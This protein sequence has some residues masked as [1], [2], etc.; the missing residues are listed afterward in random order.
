MKPVF[1]YIY[2]PVPSWRLGSSL[3][4]DLLSQEEKICNFDCVYCQLGPVKK[5]TIERK[6][7]VPVEKIIEELEMLP[8]TH[9]DY[10]TFSGRGEPTLA[11]NLGEA[12]KAVKLVRKEP[13]AVLTN[14]SLMGTNKA[15][16]ELALAD[17]VVAKLDAYSPESLQEI[18]RPANE[19]EFGSILDGIKK[20]RK[21]YGGKLALQVMFME[22]NKVY[23]SKYVYLANY[24]KPDEIQVNTPLRPCGI[25]A[26]TKEEI[27]K[28]KGNFIASCQGINV[29]CAYDER[30]E[31]S[32][33]SLSDEE[34][35]KRRGKVK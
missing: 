17:F 25:K 13:I 3:G 21:S 23:I 32:I 27:F 30:A 22:N 15:R 14:S 11:A 31:K 6:I 28:I 10:I 2:G 33:V 8:Q 1:K 16:E 26:L 5:H 19:V 4:I 20:F 12:I 34:T 35:L 9:I 24:I 29:V 18:N 7:Y